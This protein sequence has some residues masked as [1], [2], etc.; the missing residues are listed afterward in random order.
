MLLMK[1]TATG[2]TRYEIRKPPA[3]SK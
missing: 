1:V 3:Y 2:L